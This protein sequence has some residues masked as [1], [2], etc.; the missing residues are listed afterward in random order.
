MRNKHFG[1][2]DFG[3]AMISANAAEQAAQTRDHGKVRRRQ[4][5]STMNMTANRFANK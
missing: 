1:K 4:N 5:A 2:S 3:I